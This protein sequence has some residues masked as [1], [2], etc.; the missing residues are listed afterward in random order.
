MLAFCV[1]LLLQIVP[2]AQD[3]RIVVFV[4]AP[5]RDGFIDTGKD[6]QDA[7]KISAVR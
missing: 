4:T 5:T 7:I 2:A 6:V 3:H 1:A